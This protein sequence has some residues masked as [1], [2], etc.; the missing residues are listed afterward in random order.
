M[1][2]IL[3]D[4]DDLRDV[5]ATSLEDAGYEVCEA[6]SADE[7]LDLPQRSQLQLVVSDVRM[8][9]SRDGLGALAA[10]KS[11]RPALRCVVIT[12][13]ASEDA[14][15]RALEIQVDDY[16]YKPFRL[17]QLLAVV[18]RVLGSSQERTLLARL[19]AA[20]ARL[21]F[22]GASRTLEAQRDAA[23]QGFFV[24]VRANLLLRGAALDVWDQLERLEETY[25]LLGVSPGTTAAH[26]H[27]LA[28]RYHQVTQLLKAMS[29][30]S[31]VGSHRPR[32]SWQV[33]RVTFGRFY[34]RIREGQVGFEQLRVAVPLW[35]GRA[36]AGQAPEARA[37]FSA[38]WA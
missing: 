6:A 16:V 28:G 21:L 3:E 20:P 26:V 23:L 9:G 38:L 10:L 4:D 18:Q 17:A 5:L 24:A 37:L 14:P 30:S 32:E 29:Q 12:G 31:A 22:E 33:D 8:A 1:I 7:A 19:L 2:L 15:R 35:K 27:A 36:S 25:E 13:Y 11:D 34:D